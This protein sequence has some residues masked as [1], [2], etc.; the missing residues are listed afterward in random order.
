MTLPGARIPA[1]ELTSLWQ[2]AS[3]RDPIKVA[4]CNLTQWT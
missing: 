3:S 1:A 2:G 4:N